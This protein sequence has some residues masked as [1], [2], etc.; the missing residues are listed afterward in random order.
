[1]ALP[2]LNHPT[3]DVK[4]PSTNKVYTFRPYTVK[5]QKILLMLQGST[6]PEEL[7]KTVKELI[8]A[9]C[10]GAINIDKLAY[11]DIEYLLLR[12]RA[13][14]VG[15]ISKLSYKCNNIVEG[16]PCSTN[17]DIDI[18]MFFEGSKPD[19]IKIEI[20]VLL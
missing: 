17:V 3:F 16:A 18:I 6:D 11:F 10:V 5:E 20:S 9:T 1:M 4:I 2:K 15:E 12:L 19:S 8:G 13:K 14:S 7:Y